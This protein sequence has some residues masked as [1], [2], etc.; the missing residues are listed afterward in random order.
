MTIRDKMKYYNNTLNSSLYQIHAILIL[1]GI[2]FFTA[3][4]SVQL[5]SGML[6]ENDTAKPDILEQRAQYHYPSMIQ[7]RDGLLH[8][9]YTYNKRETP[10]GEGKDYSIKYVLIDPK[11][12]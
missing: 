9:V 2:S 6:F 3:S 7:S 12:F 8:L 1:V 10:Y 11:E 5:K 4:A